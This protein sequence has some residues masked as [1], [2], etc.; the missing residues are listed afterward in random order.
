MRQLFANNAKTTL[1]SA[2]TDTDM[3]LALATGT[4]GKFPNP[5]V[6]QE[7]FLVTLE[8]GGVIEIVR[9][10]ARLGDVLTLDQRGLEGTTPSSFAIGSIVECRTTAATLTSFATEAEKLVDLASVDELSAPNKMGADSCICHTNDDFG[11]PILAIKNTDTRWSFTTHK[12][13]VVTGTATAGTNSTTQLTSTNIGSSVVNPTPGRYL[14]QFLTGN[15]AGI[16]RVVGV[17]GINT[18]SWVTPL[19][20]A[21]V[22]DGDQFA[23]YKSDTSVTSSLNNDTVDDAL[24]YA[25]IFS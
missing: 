3:T 23:I 1:A 7:Y 22:A 17:S 24:A 14:I 8:I 2:V 20:I 11:N 13:T 18:V 5:V 15:L 21:P 9:C 12:T 19:P 10:T 6:G 4:G 16:V 25:I